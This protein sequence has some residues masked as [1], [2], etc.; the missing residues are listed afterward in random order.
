MRK[1]LQFFLLFVLGISLAHAAGGNAKLD[2][3]ETDLSDLKS[4]QRGARTFVNYCLS[5]HSAAFMRYNR[6]GSDLGISEN[7]VKQNLMFASKKVGDLMTVSMSKEDGKAWFG[8]APPDLSVISRSRSP[9]WLYTYLRS[10]FWDDGKG[11]WDNATF[12]NVAMPHVL[13]EL[14]GRQRPVYRTQKYVVNGKEQER[15]VLD[16]LEQE[17]PGTLSKNEYD[18]VVKDLTNFMAYLGE[19]AKMVRTK[20]GIYVLLFLAVLL[21]LTYLLK[22]E[23]WKDIH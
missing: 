17:S 4:L 19:P 3:V 21:V 5:C 13:F 6:M 22:K 7:L 10:F 9:E 18:A 1:V 20:I 8:T 15:E 11:R 12:P 16:Q 23:Y 14:Q 2:P